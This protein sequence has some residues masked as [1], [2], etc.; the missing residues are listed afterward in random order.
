LHIFYPEQEYRRAWQS[1]VY[2]SLA[3]VILALPVVMMLAAITASKISR[4]MMLLQ[5]QVDRITEGD[6][7]QMVLADRDDEI[8]A[9]GM[10]V[11]QM[12][13][14]LSGYEEQVRQTERMRTL[15]QL[16]G[17][18]AHQFRNAVTGCNMALELHAE[19]CANGR[20]SESLDVAKRQLRLMEEY[21]QRFLKLGKRTENV[22]SEIVNLSDLLDDMLPLVQPAARHAGIDLHWDGAP[23]IHSEIVG[24]A[25]A[26]N[27]LVINLLLNAIEAAS[28]AHA[29][30][31]LPGR[32][33]VAL[34]EQTPGRITFSVADSGRGPA[35]NVRD[36]V[37]EPFVTEKSDGIG[38][39]LSVASDVAARHG[40]H[41]TWRRARGMTEFSVDFLIAQVEVPCA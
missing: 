12:A 16:G 36:K 14:M 40:G 35:D 20:T 2:P 11:N 38:L 19:E 4:R 25:A 23:E 24:D 37:F 26:L 39:G 27:Q 21:V 1:S 31:N 3:F 6:F 33:V 28:N 7:Q 5:H 10:A 18:V 13:T 8:R 15:A 9:L 29:T 34:S 30:S 32:V 41:L 22:L 17:G